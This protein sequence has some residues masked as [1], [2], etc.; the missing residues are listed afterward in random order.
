MTTTERPKIVSPR[1]LFRS[2]AIAEMLTWAGLITA[3]I[4]RAFDVA[5][6]VPIAGGIHGFI[7]LCYSAST[8]FVWVN[9]RWRFRIGLTGLLLAI[10]P[11]AT[12]P[13]EI[14]VD[15]RGLL[16]G[17]WRLAPGGEAPQGF[18]EHVQA[19]VL[20]HILL[21]I[22]LL[23]LLVATLFMALLWLGP[24]VPRN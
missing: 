18:I 5:D 4:L 3:L 23:I 21:S 13:F 22:I 9:Q 1:V 16:T 11:F 12:V 24:P 20:R 17:D 19:W 10:V 6:L 2:F 14:V 15:R 7:F 8:I